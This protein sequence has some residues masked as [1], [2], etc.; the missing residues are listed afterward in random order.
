MKIPD[1]NLFAADRPTLVYLKTRRTDSAFFL[2]QPKAGSS[3]LNEP[4]SGSSTS[5]EFQAGPSTSNQPQP[6]KY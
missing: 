4:Q 6:S 2:S 1:K 5:N 3:I